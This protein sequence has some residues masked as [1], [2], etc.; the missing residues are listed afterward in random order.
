MI[1]FISFAYPNFFSE[2]L[3]ISAFL[4]TALSIALAWMAAE[5]F[6]MPSLKAYGKQELRELGVTAVIVLL[7]I[8]LV[9]PGSLFDKV[10]EGLAPHPPH[11]ACPETSPNANF[12]FKQAE[13][14]LGCRM[15]AEEWTDYFSLGILGSR[16]KGILLPNLVDAY[17]N[18]MGYEI[19][20]G[21]ISTF[22][23]SANVPKPLNVFPIDL[24]V[25]NLLFGVVLNPI[26]EANT[27]LT[28]I[29]GTLIASVFVQKMLLVFVQTSVPS[30][31]LPLGL[32]MRAFP[33]TRKTGSTI[34]AFSFAAYFIYPL[35]ILVNAQI[36]NALANPQCP[37]GLLKDGEPCTQD[38]QCCSG[39]C[40]GK[41]E[42]AIGNIHKYK[43]TLK[44]CGSTDW[45]SNQALVERSI[46]QEI[47]RTKR[48][49]E[50]KNRAIE[51]SQPGSKAEARQKDALRE[52]ERLASLEQARLMEGVNNSFFSF[53]DVLNLYNQFEFLVMDIGK[54][55][56][57]VSLFIVVEIVITLTLYKD[58]SGMIGGEPR[59]MGISKMV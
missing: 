33:F 56:V 25:E 17:M 36:Y 44:F 1:D 4:F 19:A 2:P 7:A 11:P 15:N 32:V 22:G 30:V 51:S 49:Q 59:I 10:G 3:L 57:L 6:S 16:P 29:V 45:R 18:L 24:V 12:A 46:E 34:V 9:T 8:V 53:S 13:Y 43:S 35:S 50:E 27:M 47:E 31:I 23:F 37:Q 58:F 48:Y 39:L 38:A 40:T 20:T 54:Q 5:F 21:F 52:R 14:F 55:M 28:D 41:C 26:N 42:S